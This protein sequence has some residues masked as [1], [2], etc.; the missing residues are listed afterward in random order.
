[1]LRANFLVQ[2]CEVTHLHYDKPGQRGKQWENCSLSAEGTQIPL[3][4]C[5]LFTGKAVQIT[6][7]THGER[8]ALRECPRE[9]IREP[10]DVFDYDQEKSRQTLLSSAKGLMR[11]EAH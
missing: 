8:D 6:K 4:A 10:P 2:I 11:T 1:M 3:E 5:L 9:A 7:G